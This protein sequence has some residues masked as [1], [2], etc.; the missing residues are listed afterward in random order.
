MRFKFW[1]QHYEGKERY[2][3]IVLW[4]FSFGLF[5]FFV[6]PLFILVASSN[7]HIVQEHVRAFSH[8]VIEVFL[9]LVHLWDFLVFS[10]FGW[11]VGKQAKIVE[12]QWF[13]QAPIHPRHLIQSFPSPLFIRAINR[14]PTCHL[15]NI[16]VGKH[17]KWVKTHTQYI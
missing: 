2:W 9:I 7:S 10:R 1:P 14:T 8:L 17:I 11:E 5:Q 15:S 3:C 6:S 16:G 4:G 13:L 12:V